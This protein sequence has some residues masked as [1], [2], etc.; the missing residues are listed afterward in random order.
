M[1]TFISKTPNLNP[2][3]KIAVDVVLLPPEEIMDEAIEINQAL[4]KTF[5]KKIVLNKENCFPHISLAVGCIMEEDIP[6][7]DDVL[8]GI[9]ESF[10]PMMLTRIHVETI[11][12]GEK[13]S[14]FEIEKTKDIQ[15][16]HEKVMDGLSSCFIGDISRDMIYASSDERIDDFTLQWIS[17]YSEKA[18]YENFFPHI[19]LGFGELGAEDV[20][21]RL[22]LQFK[23]AKLALCHMGNH[24]TCKKIITTRLHRFPQEKQ[25]LYTFK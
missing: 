9:A 22:P 25:I 21:I 12:T 5:D 8:K 7:I 6:R 11:Q 19:T 24:C 17:N 1:I 2:Q 10:S 13:V 3:S 15:L 20:K 14:G 23:A 18:S 16:L 4:I